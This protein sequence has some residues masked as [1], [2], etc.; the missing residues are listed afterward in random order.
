M[1]LPLYADDPLEGQSRAYVTWALVAAN[2]IIFLFVFTLP[3]A[4]QE[5]LVT[6][7]GFTPVVAIREAPF[8]GSFPRDL[9]LLSSMFMHANVLHLLGNMLF[10]WVFGDDIEDAI[11][12][13]RFLI[14]YLICGIAGAL[15]FMLNDPHSKIALIGASGAISG[16]LT[17][18]LLLRPCAKIEVFVYFWPFGIRALYVIGLWI[19]IQVL[20]AVTQA[21]DG[22]AYWAHIGGVLAGAVLILFLRPAKLRLFECLWP[23]KEWDEAHGHTRR[24]ALEH[25]LVLGTIATAVLAYVSLIGQ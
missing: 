21:D 3:A 2:T 8:S 10:L 14:F 5:Y 1:V 18:F 16:V 24:W 9:T 12:H 25:V 17:A 4:W 6:T 22:V 23:T 15:L 19:A 13:L 20:S 11:G 7:L